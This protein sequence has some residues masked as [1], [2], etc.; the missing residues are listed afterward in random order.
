LLTKEIINEIELVQICNAVLEMYYA[1][2]MEGKD[3]KQSNN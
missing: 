1:C 2:K 3:G